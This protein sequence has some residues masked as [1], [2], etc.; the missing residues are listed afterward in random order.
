MKH[1]QEFD[2]MQREKMKDRKRETSFVMWQHLKHQNRKMC[3]FNCLEPA[4]CDVRDQK[5]ESF[6]GKDSRFC[7]C[8]LRNQKNDGWMTTEQSLRGIDKIRQRQ[9]KQLRPLLLY[10]TR[11]S[12]KEWSEHCCSTLKNRFGSQWWRNNSAS[13]V[14][15]TINERIQS[16]DIALITLYAIKEHT[17]RFIGIPHP[18]ETLLSKNWIDNEWVI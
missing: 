13:K 11:W 9:D 10:L 2:W 1:K 15:S 17:Y 6:F 16:N 3:S 7:S 14:C 4:I 12:K 18:L 5:L 8:L